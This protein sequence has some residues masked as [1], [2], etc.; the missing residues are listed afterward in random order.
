MISQRNKK[1][2]VHTDNR[3]GLCK[4]QVEHMFHVISSCSRM[5]S[6]CYLPLRYD[7]IAKYVYEQHSMILVPR[8]K[9]EY[10]ASEFIHSEGNIEYWWNLPIKTAMKTKNNKPDFIIWNSEI[11]TCQVVELSCPADVNVSKKV[12]EK[13]NIYGPL[14][15]SMQLLYPD[16]QLE[17]IPIIVGALGSL[18]T[19]LL[20]AL[21]A[22]ALQG[23]NPIE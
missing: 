19:C 4:N 18:P 15:R 7:A 22:L 16:Y 20:R 17:F 8:C 3:C 2:G 9:V 23:R 11:K 14:I 10:P 6:R 21:N 1:V 5:S 12:S 13:E